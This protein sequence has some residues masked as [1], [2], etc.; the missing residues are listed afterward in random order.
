MINGIAGVLIYTS[1]DRFPAM[2]RFYVE[3]LGLQPRSDR[4]GFVNFDFGTQRLTVAVHSEINAENVDP[5]HV[6]VNLLTG[7]VDGV[8]S[9]AVARGA[10]HRARQRPRLSSGPC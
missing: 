8:Y 6:M 3:V 1:Q 10:G 9:L 2:R 5:L 7:D 4:D